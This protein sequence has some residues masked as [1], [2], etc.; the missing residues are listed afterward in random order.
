MKSRGG[1]RI[2]FISL[3]FISWSNLSA[4]E[5]N[6]PVA[7]SL[8]D[9]NGG[10][11]ALVGLLSLPVGTVAEI[12]AIVARE[13]GGIVPAPGFFLEVVRV[14]GRELPTKIPMLF[15]VSEASNAKL[16][17]TPGGL[18]KLLQDLVTPGARQRVDGPEVTSDP[19]MEKKEAEE[20]GKNYLGSRHKLIVYE[21]ATIAGTPAKIPADSEN[22]RTFQPF[23]VRTYLE[24]LAER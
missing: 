17:T 20:Y 1:L 23:A 5:E 2:F 22:L 21:C 7:V 11:V 16:A 9:I 14:N 4:A 18:K 6:K 3:G 8:A 24:V 12:E 19:P 10:K 15:S 13:E